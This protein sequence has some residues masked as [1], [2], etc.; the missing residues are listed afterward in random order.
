[1]KFD[2]QKDIKSA[3]FTLEKK[4]IPNVKAAVVLNLDVSGSSRGLYRDGLMS[5]FVTKIVPLADLF[6][7]NN[8]L[9]VFIFD[10]TAR[11][12]APD[13]T[14][15]NYDGYVE[16]N[17]INSGI[18]KWGGTEYAPFIEE[19]LRSLGYYKEERSGGLFGFGG[20]K[21]KT[22]QRD[23]GSGFPSIIFCLTDGANSDNRA[24]YQILKECEEAGT[25][26][27]FIFV[28]IGPA[29]EFKNIVKYG[30]DFSNVGFVS[31]VN[32]EKFLGSDDVYDLILG[33][34]LVDWFKR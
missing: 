25:Q 29:N 5:A 1:M 4:G 7:D 20:S 28:G 30:D 21:K 10:N 2:I 8:S 17:I 13:V 15:N 31:A 34:E 14:L 24:T 26:A 19:N 18:D 23:N 16:K 11:P 32:F 6:D 9:Q 3:K 27:Y 33:Q 12:I 22:L